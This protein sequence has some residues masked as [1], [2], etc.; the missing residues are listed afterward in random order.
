MAQI[1]TGIAS[2]DEI[3]PLFDPV[4]P[5]F[6][7]SNIGMV[8]LL[9]GQHPADMLTHRGHFRTRGPHVIG[10][11]CHIPANGA[12]MLEEQMFDLVIHG[13]TLS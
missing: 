1:A 9:Q 4:E 11:P 3:E 5:R 13:K 10:Q 8:M 12:E 7:R 6:Q 2:V